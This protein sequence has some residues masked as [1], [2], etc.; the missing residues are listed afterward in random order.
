MQQQ[1]TGFDAG[2]FFKRRAE[3]GDGRIAQYRGNFSNT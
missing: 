3:M 1:F 2:V